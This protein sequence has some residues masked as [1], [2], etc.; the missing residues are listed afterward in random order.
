MPATEL[1][2]AS[3]YR[4]P[5]TATHTA[6]AAMP[7]ACTCPNCGTAIPKPRRNQTY[8][9]GACRAEATERKRHRNAEPRMDTCPHCG[10]RFPKTK[11]TKVFCSPDCQQAFNNHW[12]AR[13]PELALAMIDWRVRKVPG[14]MTKVCRAFSRAREDLDDKRAKA[15]A[16]KGNTVNTKKGK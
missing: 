14:G 2:P 10:T 6:E 8:C 11:K 4:G 15:H 12:K 5:A 13:G 3:V 9:S 1:V 7:T 16:A